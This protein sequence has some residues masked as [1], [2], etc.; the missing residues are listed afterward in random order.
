MVK[1]EMALCQRP[2][3]LVFLTL[4]TDWTVL[5]QSCNFIRHTLQ[6]QLQT[7]QCISHAGKAF[8]FEALR[9]KPQMKPA[10]AS[11]KLGLLWEAFFCR[12]RSTL[13]S[14]HGCV[15]NQDAERPAETWNNG[16]IFQNPLMDW[17]FFDLVWHLK[18][19]HN[20]VIF[21]TKMKILHCNWYENPFWWGYYGMI[22]MILHMPWSTEYIN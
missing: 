11:P 10:T 18:T 22:I 4:S 15:N 20:L 16:F 9:K 3:W 14:K 12:C 7:L 6:L 2:I 19:Q 5:L 17:K 21:L 8:V 1:K 13:Y